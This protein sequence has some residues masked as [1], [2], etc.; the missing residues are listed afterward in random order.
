MN[1][2]IIFMLIFVVL[3]SVLL[4]FTGIFMHLNQNPLSSKILIIGFLFTIL[5]SVVLIFHA[6][7]KQRENAVLFSILIL[8]MPIIGAFIYLYNLLNKEKLKSIIN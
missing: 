2:K 6:L 5:V 4:L 7:I 8:F 1:R 3:I